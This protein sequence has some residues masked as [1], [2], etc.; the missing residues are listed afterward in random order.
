MGI[1]SNNSITILDDT[2][3]IGEVRIIKSHVEILGLRIVNE[4]GEHLYIQ[5]KFNHITRDLLELVIRK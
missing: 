3:R 2:M 5:P 4:T 1:L